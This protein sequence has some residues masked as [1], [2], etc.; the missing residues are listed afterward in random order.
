[1]VKKQAKHF[2]HTRGELPSAFANSYRVKLCR[3][4]LAW[5]LAARTERFSESPIVD[6]HR[7]SNISIK[8][9]AAGTAV[10]SLVKSLCFD[11]PTLRARLRSP[12]W[13]HFNQLATS[14]YSFVA[15]HFDE[16]T[17]RG[18]TNLCG[19]NAL[20]HS[21]HIQAFNGNSAEPVNYLPA[22][23]V[24]KIAPRRANSKLKFTDLLLAFFAR[25]RAIFAAGKRPFKATLFGRASL[26]HFGVTDIVPITQ[27]NERHKSKIK[28]DTVRAC[29]I[30]RKNGDVE[31]YVPLVVFVNQNGSFWLAWQFAMPF[32]FDFAWNTNKANLAAFLY[33]QAVAKSKFGCPVVPCRLKP[34]KSR[35]FAALATSKKGLKRLVQLSNN[36]LLGSRRPAPLVGK[37]FANLRQCGLL[38]VATYTNP[39]FVSQNPLFQRRIIQLTK[40]RKHFGQKR[41]L[42]LVGIDAVTV[43][44]KL[45]TANISRLSLEAIN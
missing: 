20:G 29:A 22:F 44:Q 9:A 26:A 21:L 24:K 42:C 19:Q 28:S 18:V 32:Y 30:N 43:R 27:G 11:S 35:L 38:V 33:G 40:I 1:M 7:S 45:H 6:Y 23:F 2:R 41:S 3:N 36:A 39:L 34:W 15:K 8:N 5:R 13:V 12:S 10:L 4:R 16:Y 17:P 14:V 25:P 31:N 37:F